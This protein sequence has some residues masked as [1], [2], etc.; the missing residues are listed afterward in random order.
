MDM[1]RLP[2]K[3]VATLQ[4]LAG[5]ALELFPIMFSTSDRMPGQKA[6][7][8]IPLKEEPKDPIIDFIHVFVESKLNVPPNDKALGFT[9]EDVTETTGVYV[10][11]K[12]NGIIVGETHSLS[13][14]LGEIITDLS[15]RNRI[16]H[17]VEEMRQK[18]H[19]DDDFLTVMNIEWLA[20]PSDAIFG[21]KTLQ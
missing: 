19:L 20:R 5:L 3:S 18:V 9:N 12:K 2:K 10:F 15:L 4:E 14:L 16:L 8:G 13:M 1:I 17:R 21:F 7:F 6:Y 11:K